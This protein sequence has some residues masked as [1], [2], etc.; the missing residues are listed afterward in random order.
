MSKKS[1]KTGLDQEKIVLALSAVVFVIFSITLNGFFTIDNQLSILQNASII[2][3]LGIAMAF[4][5]IGR[6]IDLSMIAT[7]VMPVA[8]MFIEIERGESWYVVFMMGVL[9]AIIIGTFNGFLVAHLEIPP[10]FA[11]LASGTVVYGLIQ[12]IAVSDD[13]VNLPKKLD[14]L[15]SK[16]QGFTYGLPNIII[17]FL[18]I[19]IGSDYILRKTV[20]GRYIYAIGVNPATSRATGLPLRKI[21]ILQYVITALMTMCI[22]L[23]LAASVNSVNTRLFNSTIIYDVVLVVVLGGIGLGGGKGGVVNVIAGTMLMGILTNGMTIMD[24]PYVA[25]NF[26][27]AS[28]LLAAIVV[29]NLINPRDEQ[30]SQQGDI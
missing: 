6:G 9:V 3:A 21:I 12:K 30:S 8:W 13:L 19:A 14:W 24:L 17:F 1:K 15:A 26:V 22:G 20:F 2:G 7:L 29:D 16:V 4:V 25:Q 5:V 23:V 27:R 28:I 10:I 11:T 18:I